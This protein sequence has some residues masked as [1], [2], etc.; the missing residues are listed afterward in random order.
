MEISFSPDGREI[1][2]SALGD[3]GTPSIWVATLDRSSAPLMLQ[4]AADDPR[5][6]PAFIYYRKRTPA[7]SYAHRV[8]PDGSGDEQIWEL[9]SKISRLEAIADSAHELRNKP[10]QIDI[11]TLEEHI[12]NCGVHK[13]DSCA[14]CGCKRDHLL[15]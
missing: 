2:F 3:D 6:T 8:H 10:R 7:G 15:L 12:A 9:G 11:D 5:F 13:E 4:N 1:A 14:C